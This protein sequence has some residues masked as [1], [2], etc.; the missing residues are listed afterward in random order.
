MLSLSKTV[1]VIASVCNQKI[2]DSK[3]WNKKNSFYLLHFFTKSSVRIGKLRLSWQAHVFKYPLC[4]Y[5]S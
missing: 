3:A 4:L 2:S 5:L 1:W